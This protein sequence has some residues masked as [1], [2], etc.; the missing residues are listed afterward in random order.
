MNL[1][2]WHLY[3]FDKQQRG[4]SKVKHSLLKIFVNKPAWIIVFS[5]TPLKYLL[6]ATLSVPLLRQL[7]TEDKTANPLLSLRAVIREFHLQP[8]LED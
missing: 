5:S 6:F 3:Y 1:Y 7:I 8:H 4:F 2:M